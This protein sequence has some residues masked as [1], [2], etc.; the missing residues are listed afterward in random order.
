[1]PIRY[2]SSSSGT[3]AYAPDAS[4]PIGLLCDPCPPVIF[5]RSHFHRQVSPRPYDTR[6]PSSERWNC[7]WECWPVILP[8]CRLP[9]FIYGSFTCRKSATWDWQPYFPSE[10]RRAE[11]FF[12]LK[13]P[14]AFGRVWTREPGYLTLRLL[15]FYIYIWSTYSWCF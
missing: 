6:D 5:R 15:M 2:S 8:K 14:N 3:G 7:G 9:H 11:D 4:Q 1:M 10:G 12:A 13:N